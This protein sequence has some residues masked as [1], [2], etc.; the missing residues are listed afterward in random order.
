M[1][2]NALARWLL[3]PEPP[4]LGLD[5]R[6][7]EISLVRASERRSGAE[8]DVCVTSPL[9]TGCLKF[10]MLEPNI[11]DL[12]T[13]SQVVESILVKSGSAASRKI[14][15]TLPDHLSRVSIVEL[16][17]APGSHDETI[18]M[19]KFRLKKSLPFDSAQARI[20][21]ERV[22]GSE[23]TFLTGVMH[24]AVV[25]QYEEFLN[26]LGFHVGLILPAS[27]SL[28]RVVQPLAAEQLAPGADYFF[29]NVEREYFTVNLVRDG[30]TLVLSRTLGLRASDG[31]PVIYTQD[32]L[33]QE[34][35]PTAIYY[36]EKLKGTALERVYYRSLRPDMTELRHA[37]EDQFQA[38]SEPMDLMSA[39]G[40][41]KDLNLDPELAD[42]VGAAA[43][44]ALG[45]VA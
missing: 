30:G 39:V 29:V 24:E 6:Q 9:P 25:S 1:V 22:R 37:L 28:L 36:R 14:A 27:L 18:E 4:G 43:G 32:D 34:I 12:Q 17:E 8:L 44:A 13:L 21:F 15:L 41:A 10:E 26:A 2:A 40:V 38:P 45:R 19:L 5:I 7:S 35:I 42:S 31:P 33:I 11:Q 16:P 3:E 20:A 23:P